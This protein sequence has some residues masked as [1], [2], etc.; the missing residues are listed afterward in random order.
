MINFQKSVSQLHS[1]LFCN[2]LYQQF[3]FGFCPLQS[4]EITLIKITNDLLAA[5]F[6][7]LWP[8]S[9]LIWVV[10]ST[11]SHP[12][13]FWTGLLVFHIH[14]WLDLTSLTVLQLQ[15][16][17]YFTSHSVPVTN[18]VLQGSILVFPRF[19]FWC[20][21][22]FCHGVQHSAILRPTME[23]SPSTFATVT[24]FF[25]LKLDWK[26]ICL[27]LR[28]RDEQI[29]HIKRW[30]WCHNPDTLLSFSIYSFPL[31]NFIYFIIHYML[32]LFIYKN[33]TINETKR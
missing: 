31:I 20:F 33:D 13:S 8:S 10:P 1:Y 17:K 6:G 4:T 25:F 24:L 29:Q 22:G 9:W 5:D 16:F 28:G 19:L 26:L 32:L 14:P 18:G 7:L 3:H 15:P 2:Y 27:S 23:L 21:P 30:R 12:P 11:P